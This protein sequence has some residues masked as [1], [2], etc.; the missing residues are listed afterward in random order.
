MGDGP[1]DVVRLCKIVNLGC[2]VAINS[3]PF[4]Y[5]YAPISH[6]DLADTCFGELCKAGRLTQLQ[7]SGNP[8]L[9]QWP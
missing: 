7:K 6:R 8:R 4:W 9:V 5:L 2:T 3:D 1:L